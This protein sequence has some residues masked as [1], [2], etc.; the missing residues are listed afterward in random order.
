VHHGQV[1]RAECGPLDGETAP[2]V[3]YEPVR[4][5]GRILPALLRGTRPF[6]VNSL[7]DA[8][9]PGKKGFSFLRKPDGMKSFRAA[10]RPEAKLLLR[11]SLLWIGC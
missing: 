9:R 2:F 6:P 11:A 1:T 4:F 10:R 7:P 5:H 3:S 8:A